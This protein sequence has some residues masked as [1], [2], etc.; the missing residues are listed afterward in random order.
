[1]SKRSKN[2]L[3]PV[4]YDP[5]MPILQFS[6]VKRFLVFL[7][8]CHKCQY[9]L[10]V[11][12]IALFW[13]PNTCLLAK[14]SPR[15]IAFPSSSPKLHIMIHDGKIDYHP[16]QQQRHIAIIFTQEKPKLEVK[17]KKLLESLILSHE[18]DQPRATMTTRRFSFSRCY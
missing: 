6:F 8:A 1:M 2:C 14:W 12:V 9:S 13:L 5:L 17:Q 10:P 15:I 7:V 11:N 3:A 16:K 4:F 18:T